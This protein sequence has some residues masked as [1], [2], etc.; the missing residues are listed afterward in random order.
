VKSAALVLLLL[1]PRAHAD[2]IDATVRAFVVAA[3]S[4]EQNNAL[5]KHWKPLLRVDC[6]SVARLEIDSSDPANVRAAVTYA[7]A[8]RS[9]PSRITYRDEHLTLALRPQNGHWTIDRATVDEEEL[10]ARIAA[11]APADR[12]AMLDANPQLLNGTLARALYARCRIATMTSIAGSDAL[13]ETALR[14]AAWSGDAAAESL[15]LNIRVNAVRFTNVDAALGLSEASLAIAERIDDPTAM[16]TALVML[17]NIEQ[18]RGSQSPHAVEL[19]QRAANMQDCEDLGQIGKAQYNLAWERVVAYD[20]VA[21]RR[22]AEQAVETAREAESLGTEGYA[23]QVLGLIYEQQNDRTMALHHYGAALDAMTSLGAESAMPRLQVLM[24]ECYVAS[25]AK[26]DRA[27]RLL[28]QAEA[29]AARFHD[30]VT[31]AG[32]HRLR[33]LMAVKRGDVEEAECW[34]R[35]AT[36]LFAGNGYTANEL[37]PAAEAALKKREYRRAL[38]LAVDASIVVNAEWSARSATVLA[39][40]SRANGDA[41]AAIALLRYV[42]ETSDRVIADAAVVDRTQMTLMEE[43]VGAYREL[44]ALLVDKGRIDEAFRVAEQAK[45]R[46]LLKTLQG[47]KPDAAFPIAD[48][49]RRKEAALV[50]REAELSRALA[51]AR[52]TARTQ[53]EEQLAV[54]RNAVTSFRDALAVKYPQL[55]VSRSMLDLRTVGELSDLLLEPN[56]IFLEYAIAGRRLDIY[57]LR[58]ERRGLT[59]R[60]VV[61][62]SEALLTQIKHLARSFRTR[63]L[64]FDRRARELY[65][66]LI[67]PVADLLPSGSTI[68]IVPDGPLWLVPFAALVD[69]HGRYLLQRHTITYAPSVHV[70]AAMHRM[71]ESRLHEPNPRLLAFGNPQ[72]AD[73]TRAAVRAEYR[74]VDLGALPEAEDEVRALRSIYGPRATVYTGRTATEARVRAEAP[75]FDILHFATHGVVDPVSP[76]YSRLILSTDDAASDGMLEA[77]EISR[78]SLRADLVV[79]SACD[80]ARA[81]EGAGEGLIGIAWAFM[82]AGC[83]RTVATLTKVDSLAARELMVSFHRRMSADRMR[84]SAAALRDAQLAMLADRRHAH[85]F[86][87]ASF[88]LIGADR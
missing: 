43:H 40:A 57:V 2:A 18:L 46:V 20:M 37:Y 17:G 42:V 79:L 73:A 63:D 78:L 41:D 68:C 55:A 58:P 25:N 72:L 38:A 86:Y 65:K 33:G 22:F 5:A 84:G 28:E 51:A 85:P 4:G 76:M 44:A 77:G 54:A 29:G 14:V 6:I 71:Q 64:A 61:I 60:S 67:A 35:D 3:A 27:A 70:Y 34:Y 48:A 56:T 19:F 23:H 8:P 9:N 12:Q 1:A 30:A 47:G 52:G 83:P 13:A 69:R 80:T 10:A 53:L 16:A 15:I 75:R 39:E 7:L 49:E 21:A 81:G 74:D 88:V 24:A 36:K 62:E 45:G 50:Q 32:C 31:L 87:W 82:V 26:L 11:A 59:V 66:V